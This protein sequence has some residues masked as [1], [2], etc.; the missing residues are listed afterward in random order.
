MKDIT[1]EYSQELLPCER[2]W[3]TNCCAF[4]F[5]LLGSTYISWIYDPMISNESLPFVKVCNV[6]CVWFWEHPT[7]RETWARTSEILWRGS[8]V[9]CRLY[10]SNDRSWMKHIG[11]LW[12]WVVVLCSHVICADAFLVIESC[13]SNL[14]H[15]L[16]KFLGPGI[17]NLYTLVQPCNLGLCTALG[18]LVIAHV[19]MHY[20][21]D[22]YDMYIRFTFTSICL[23]VNIYGLIILS[24]CYVHVFSSYV[25]IPFCFW[26]L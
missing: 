6:C 16:V 19:Y 5:S 11:A 24:E 21:F 12:F 1:Q 17:C 15:R 2:S 20:W 26:V 22:V 18:S 25:I 4:L 10:T 3:K 13:A 7:S 9:R 14:T 23:Y 8:R